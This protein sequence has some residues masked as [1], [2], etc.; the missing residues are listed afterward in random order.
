M[1]EEAKPEFTGEWEMIDGSMPSI[2]QFRQRIPGGWLVLCAM[3][4]STA[5]VIVP[6]ATSDWT[7]PIKQ[8]RKRGTAF[9]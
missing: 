2:R 6:D 1:S 4:E 8:S 7:P 3:E 9:N 5:M